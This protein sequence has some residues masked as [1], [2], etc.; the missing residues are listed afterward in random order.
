MKED[1]G[2]EAG[3]ADL[4]FVNEEGG[5]EMKRKERREEVWRW[6]GGATA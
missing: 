3:A 4:C 6:R 5:S 2:V 1:G